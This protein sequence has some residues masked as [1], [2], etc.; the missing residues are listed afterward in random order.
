MKRDIFSGLP[1]GTKLKVTKKNGIAYYA[2]ELPDVHLT[3]LRPDLAKNPERCF[4]NASVY[5]KTENGLFCITVNQDPDN[6]RWVILYADDP[7][8]A[9]KYDMLDESDMRYMHVVVDEP[10]YFKN[11]KTMP[12]KGIVLVTT[13]PINDESDINELPESELVESFKEK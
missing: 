9:A 3:T 11:T 6:L 13:V 2:A 4:E 12:V 1:V 7:K 8:S 5:F 10:F